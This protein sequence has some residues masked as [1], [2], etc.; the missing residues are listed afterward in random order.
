MVS[1]STWHSPRSRISPPSVSN[2]VFRACCPNASRAMIRSLPKR[3]RTRFSPV[4]ETTSAI[5]ETLPFG[6]GVL[7]ELLAKQLRTMSGVPVDPSDFD[8]ERLPEHLR[9]LMIVRDDDGREVARGRSLVEL[10]SRLGSEIP[11]AFRRRVDGALAVLAE[12]SS[13]ELPESPLSEHIVVEGAA[14]GV[15]AWLAFQ[16]KEGRVEVSGHSRRSDAA[17][18]HR[19][20]LL[21][22]LKDLSGRALSG[23]L[24]WLLGNDRSWPEFHLLGAECDLR[25]AVELLTLDAAFFVPGGGRPR[26]SDWAVS[27]PRRPEDLFRIR[28]SRHLAC[29][30]RRRGKARGI[31]ATACDTCRRA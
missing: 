16:R 13:T 8:Q 14:G 22:E 4:R 17:K 7:A 20:F 12:S 31:D 2:G 11:A 30:G 23:H 26:L 28:I 6:E 10:R 9:M 3:L 15:R 1:R 19:D 18:Q 27:M 24:D 25:T 21:G 5:V 29:R